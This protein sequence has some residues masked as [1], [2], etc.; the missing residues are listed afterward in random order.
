MQDVTLTFLLFT[1]V[2]NPLL[3]QL[4]VKKWKKFIGRHQGQ[5]FLHEEDT[6]DFISCK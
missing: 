4:S 1:K 3:K 6:E 5:S 2:M